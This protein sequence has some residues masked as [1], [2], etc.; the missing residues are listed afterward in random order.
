MTITANF[1][2]NLHIQI[3]TNYFSERQ[4]CKTFRKLIT[5]SQYLYNRL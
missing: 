2:L 5:G 1:F 3:T 4:V